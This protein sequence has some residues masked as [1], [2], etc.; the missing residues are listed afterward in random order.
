MKKISI[1]PTKLFALGGMQEIG[2]STL[3]VE[4]KSDIVIIDAGIKFADYFASGIKGIVPD[5]SYLKENQ[6]K[7]KGI[8][9]THGHEDH[10]GGVVYLVQE[11]HITK[12]YAPRIAIQYLKAKFEERN[13][14]LKIEFIEINKNDVHKFDNI[15]VDFWTA[16]HSIPDAFGVRVSTPNGSIMCTGDFRFDY[17]PI[18]N[19]TD[20]SKLEKIGDEG[21]SVLLSDST[22]AMR[23]F[24]SPSEKD[25]LKDIE[26][27]MLEAKRKIIVTTFASNLTRVKVIIELAAKLGKKVIAFGRSM[28]NGIQ[29]GRKMG[30]IN[31][32][33]ELFINKKNINKYDE[34]E[35]V[36]LTTGSQGEQMSALSRMAIGKHPQVT[37]KNNDLVIFSSS[38]IPGNRIK[39]ELLVNKLYKLGAIIKEN[40]IDG[41]LHTSGHAYKEEHEKIFRLTRPKYFVTYHG[42]FRMSVVHGQTAV[43]NGV[44]PNNIIIPRIGEVLHLV[45]NNLYK[46]NE[47]IKAGVVFVDGSNISKINSNLIKDRVVLGENGFV[48]VVV[49][50]DKNKNIIV[51]RPRIISRGCFFVKNST[52]LIEKIKKIV[53]GAILFTIKNKDNWTIP[54]L[55]QLIKDRLEP[56]FYK[57]KRRN[58]IIMSTFL[59][60]DEQ[61]NP[62]KDLENKNPKEIIDDFEM[63]EDL[64]EEKNNEDLHI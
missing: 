25:I 37:I 16:Q 35:L 18:G 13:I 49:A 36:I 44:N 42:E 47:K 7:I 46:S 56:F 28:V 20:F 48:Y 27:Y 22:N 4:Y 34:N 55:K 33:D 61:T 10:I 5:Y 41:Y 6:N 21:L 11:V 40:G 59:F 15:K 45:K 1:V 9:I 54:E 57:E 64:D 63:D 24:H 52:E 39:I 31:A 23:P 12:I 30:Y 3:V 50:L 29:I 32:S 58:P 19:F 14:R 51:G 26:N 53:H 62:L 38:P 2:K 17:T 43:E 8:F 60:V